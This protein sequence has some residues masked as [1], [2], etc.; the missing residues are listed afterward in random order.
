MDQ[1]SSPTQ[2]PAPELSVAGAS[3]G[4]ARASTIQPVSGRRRQSFAFSAADSFSSFL[5]VV[6]YLCFFLAFLLGPL[7]YAFY[8]S[9]HHWSTIGG[10]LGFV[11]LDHYKSLLTD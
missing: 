7:I 2:T 11:G 8:V 5:F 10:N 1:G 3:S 6:P 9:L 4:P